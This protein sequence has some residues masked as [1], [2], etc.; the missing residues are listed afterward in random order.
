MYN[1]PSGAAF[2]VGMYAINR[3][4]AGPATATQQVITQ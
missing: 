4:G 2:K 3:A 1:L